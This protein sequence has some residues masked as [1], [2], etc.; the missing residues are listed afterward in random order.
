[1]ITLV[2]GGARSGKSGF[3]NRLANEMADKQNCPVTFIATAE[4]FDE[5][6]QARINKH[7]QERAAFN[8]QVIEAPT[9]LTHTLL[10]I[11]RNQVI[12]IDCLTLWLNNL[13]YYQKMT[14]IP[15]FLDLLE[16]HQNII[17]VSNELGQGVLPADKT[18]REF[19]DQV[20][21]L[22]QKIA[23]IADKVYFVTAGIA[24]QLK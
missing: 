12:L 5:G 3:A 20:G 18:S 24:Q 11:P 19:I 21:L 7:Q 22:N 16:K 4:A 9:D 23:T 6:M 17:L 15:S 1:M 13:I 14:E 2:L 8:W 10:S